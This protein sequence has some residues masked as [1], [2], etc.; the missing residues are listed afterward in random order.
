[1]EMSPSSRNTS[2]KRMVSGNGVELAKR[3]MIQSNA[4]D[5]FGVIFLP[6]TLAAREEKSREHME[7]G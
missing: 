2:Q 7:N 4:K 3:R 5:R 1:M 6:S